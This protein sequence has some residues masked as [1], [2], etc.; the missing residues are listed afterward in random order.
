MVIIYFWVNWEKYVQCELSIGLRRETLKISYP[1]PLTF[2]SCDRGPSN[3]KRMKI[4]V[5]SVFCMGSTDILPARAFS[6]VREAHMLHALVIKTLWLYPG[7]FL[8][9]SSILIYSVAVLLLKKRNNVLLWNFSVW[10]ELTP[11]VNWRKERLE[12]NS[13]WLIALSLVT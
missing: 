5:E 11:G 13:M 9:H 6:M 8:I 3:N 4:W 12:G 1:R 10:I 7:H 2:F